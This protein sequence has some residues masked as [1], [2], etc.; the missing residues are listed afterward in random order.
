[1]KT[2]DPRRLAEI[3]GVDLE[4]AEEKTKTNGQAKRKTK[5]KT[6]GKHFGGN[7]WASRPRAEVERPAVL[8]ESSCR[9][10]DRPCNQLHRKRSH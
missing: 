3:L 2:M 5:S 7:D 8:F 4:A 1:M 9:P 6:N 10:S